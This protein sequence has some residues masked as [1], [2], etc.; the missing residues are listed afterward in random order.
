MAGLAMII[1]YFKLLNFICVT[2][3][4]LLANRN[5]MPAKKMVKINRG[6]M[7]RTSGI[8]AA[9]MAMSSKLSPKFPKVIMEENSNARGKAVV[10]VLTETK[11]IN[12]KMVKRSKPF[13]TKSS[14]YSQKNC[15]V[16]TKVEIVSAA[17]KGPIKAL[18]ISMS[19]FLNKAL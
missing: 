11:P 3:M 2:G 15:M 5:A 12:S 18:R 10:M 17:K 13:P 14:M 8:P 19:N 16:S 9:L 1:S 6:R 7:K 4:M